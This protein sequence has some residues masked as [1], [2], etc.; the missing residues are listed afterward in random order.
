MPMH[1]GIS[2][3]VTNQ[4]LAD[5]VIGLSVIKRCRTM[6]SA[7]VGYNLHYHDWVVDNH[8]HFYVLTNTS[9]DFCGYGMPTHTYT[10]CLFIQSLIFHSQKEQATYRSQTGVREIITQTRTVKFVQLKGIL[11]KYKLG[12]T[13]QYHIL[14]NGWYS[15]YLL[16]INWVYHMHEFLQA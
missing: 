13:G 3:Q 7:Y 11:S 8:K 10:L 14:G 4:L 6:K 15:L 9:T 5:L 1:K 12:I 16:F 2:Y